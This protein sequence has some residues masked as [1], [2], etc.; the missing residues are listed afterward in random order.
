M[1]FTTNIYA[2]IC[3]VAYL[4]LGSN[5]KC[6]LF[7]SKILTVM[8]IGFLSDEL[9]TQWTMYESYVILNLFYCVVILSSVVKKEFMIFA[10]LVPLLLFECYLILDPLSIP[11]WAISTLAETDYVLHMSVITYI[12]MDG[13][14]SQ[15]LFEQSGRHF[16]L[17]TICISACLFM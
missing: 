10:P 14:L 9:T 4:I 5:P 12:L 2:V 3:Y 16:I 8:F 6:K 7:C 15:D 13:F 1:I 11:Y 17:T